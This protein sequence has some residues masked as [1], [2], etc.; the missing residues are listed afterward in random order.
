MSKILK[1][2][3]IGW[4]FLFNFVEIGV[5]RGEGERMS[6]GEECGKNLTA[7]ARRR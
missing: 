6:M 5:R 3:P 1:S 7:K 4:L 2:C